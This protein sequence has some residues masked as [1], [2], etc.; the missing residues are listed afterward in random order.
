VKNMSV[1][2]DQ[3][4]HQIKNHQSEKLLFS[5]VWEDPTIEADLLNY[6]S[7]SKIDPDRKKKVLIVCSGGDTLLHIVSENIS[8]THDLSDV[9][10][11][12]VDVID[13]NRLQIA[14]CVL[15]LL[16]IHY[17][18]NYQSA[19]DSTT[20]YQKIL[21]GG[22][23]IDFDEI[24]DSLLQTYKDLE[25]TSYLNVW[26]EN[27][28]FEKLERGLA[29]VGELESTFADLVKTQMN[30]NNSFDHGALTQRF[31]E[32]A[33]NLSSKTTFSDRFREIHGR[34]VQHYGTGVDSNRFYHRMLKG[35]DRF[36]DVDILHKKFRH[37]TMNDLKRVRFILQDLPS[38]VRECN[39]SGVRYD[40]IQ[41]S[42][43]TDWLNTESN[44]RSF[45]NDVITNLN[46]NGLVLWRSLNGE[47]DL[48]NILNEAS[49]KGT[50]VINTPTIDTS[51]FYKKVVI[52]RK[53]NI[54]TE[55]GC[56]SQHCYFSKLVG[57]D[58][59]SERQF[60]ETQIPFFHAVKHWIEILRSLKEKIMLSDLSHSSIEGLTKIV[61]ENIDDES[62]VGTIG[63]VNSDSDDK[64]TDS[65][66]N[67]G[68]L[69][70]NVS[71]TETFTRF[72]NGW[73][74]VISEKYGGLSTSILPDDVPIRPHVQR[75]I[76]TLYSV[77]NSRSLQF[78][79]A[80]LGEIEYIYIS[81]SK[82]IKAFS[83]LHRVDQPH[84]LVH[85][86]IDVKHST[87]LFEMCTIVSEDE[88]TREVPPNS[89]D[90]LSG[91]EFGR[92]VFLQLYSDMVPE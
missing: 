22:P 89:I 29:T 52:S 3:I 36:L 45:V 35:Q 20:S 37:V 1:A 14:T 74:S 27:N 13:N 68:C 21:H 24:L 59:F 47:Y 15:K 75:F 9:N 16:L 84:Y 85:E 8:K 56:L 60:L 42:N 90:V 5:Y 18:T 87:E 32:S 72:L 10:M 92:K 2:S 58:R 78:S 57:E 28:N 88:I 40:L 61:Q 6:L 81:V 50:I 31:G 26:R 64:N 49:G 33:I 77:V 62:G 48:I 80:C 41:T 19:D 53:L 39:I 54:E 17:F 38:Y 25:Y 4:E 7:E 34:Y 67:V 44:V 23:G 65:S 69:C 73:N 43:I 83:D 51:Y 11:F 76:D 82:I 46:D 86:I 79:C 12:T 55:E 30:F 70:G 66:K 91:A 71:H 63:T